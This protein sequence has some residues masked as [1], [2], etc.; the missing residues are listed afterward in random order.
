M[1]VGL[2]RRYYL[3]QEFAPAFTL[4]SEALFNA[5]GEDIIYNDLNVKPR[6]NIMHSIHSNAVKDAIIEKM[7]L[8]VPTLGWTM[9]A[10]SKAVVEAGFNQ[11]DENRAF[12][13]NMEKVVEYY[14]QWVDQQMLRKMET[15][16]LTSMRTR[17]KIATIIMVRLAL[18]APYK[19]VVERTFTFLAKPPH[20]PL[21]AKCLYKTVN[22]IWY[23]AGDKATDFNF[24]TK[25][26]LLAGV[27][28]STV[29]FWL[30][31]VSSDAL[32]T[33]AHLENRL[34]KALKVGQIKSFAKELCEK[35]LSY[36]KK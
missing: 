13:G 22:H 4:L 19:A 14:F 28:L 7:M 17:D 21:G 12:E 26:A 11:G 2:G 20:M 1:Y 30:K 9:S 8:H 10:L 32:Q 24:Y 27:Y 15:F 35:G 25:R 3:E 29:K 23:I 36:L 16:D 33:R 6:G 34:S 31:D 18:M 5:I